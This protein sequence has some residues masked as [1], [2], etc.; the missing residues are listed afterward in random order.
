M[1]L[2]VCVRS[3][4]ENPY[5]DFFI[6]YYVLL[7]FDK[8][9]I[10]KSDT[11][12]YSC[13]PKYEKYVNII[14]VNNSGNRILQENIHH[15]QH[16]GCDWTF[17]PDVDEILILHKQY[18]N[19]K[20]F[21]E[22][23]LRDYPQINM[24]YFRWGVIEKYDIEPNNSFND[25]LSDY[26]VFASRFIKSMVKTSCIKLLHDPHTCKMKSNSVIYLEGGIINTNKSVHDIK[27]QSYNKDAILIHIHTRSIHNIIIKSLYTVLNSKRI[28]VLSEF[29]NYI[30]NFSEDKNIV[31]S[32]KNMI[33]QKA[34]LPFHHSSQG[35]IS[36]IDISN[37]KILECVNR[38]IN[39]EKEKELVISILNKNNIDEEHYYIFVNALNKEIKEKHRIF[40]K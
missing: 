29:I 35:Y 30:N 36:N 15:I 18:N 6:E 34:K 28:L 31:L 39:V 37:Y 25:I 3:F 33:G 11:E 17:F 22:R 27:E 8:I 10:F 13:D 16:S 7:G 26:N 4:L 32:F 12:P 14:N 2:C 23:K 5:L 1:K 19:I 9:L 20:E 38:V 24:F 21:A 40:Y